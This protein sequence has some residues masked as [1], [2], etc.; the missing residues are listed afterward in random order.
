MGKSKI[1]DIKKR[2]FLPSNEASFSSVNK[3][4][5][6]NEISKN[7]ENIKEWIPLQN[8]NSLH[9]SIKKKFPRR[10]TLS[11]GIDYIWQADL[12]DVQNI[13]KYNDNFK[14]IL[15]VIDIFSRYAWAVAIK[16][17]FGSHII[18]AFESLFKSCK[19]IP[20]S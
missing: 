4:L 11:G 12:C 3:F 10:E 8:I 5:K 15:T 7:K 6:S 17:K 14:Y 9:T 1:N 13:S 2:Y 18:E 20:L 19:R 16:R